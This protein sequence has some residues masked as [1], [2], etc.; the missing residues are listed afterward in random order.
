VLAS[1]TT[2]Q[3]IIDLAKKNSYSAQLSGN[4]NKLAALNYA[5]FKMAGKPSLSFYGNAP[6]FNKDNYAV[7][8]PDGSIKFLSR[9][10]N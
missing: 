7:T 8:Q 5:A 9:S 4:E 3:Q 10:Q 6:V 2:L 1:Q